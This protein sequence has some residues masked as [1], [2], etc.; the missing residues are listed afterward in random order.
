LIIFN[1]PGFLVERLICN[2]AGMKKQLIVGLVGLVYL[3]FC[4]AGLGLTLAAPQQEAVYFVHTDGHS[5]EYHASV[6]AK[7]AIKA[8]FAKKPVKAN[9][10]TVNPAFCFAT[11][12]CSGISSAQ[13]IAV[14]QLPVKSNAD[15]F[16]LHCSFLL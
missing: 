16:L 7:S 6:P 15:R 8:F 5:D 3:V 11:T 4:C 14:N 9:P 1:I 2:F 13:I 10:S 12:A